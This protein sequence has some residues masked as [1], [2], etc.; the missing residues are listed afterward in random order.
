MLTKQQIETAYNI[1]IK[2]GFCG[3]CRWTLD[4]KQCHQRGCYQHAVKIIQEVMRN[5]YKE[6]D[7]EQKLQE[8]TNCKIKHDN[9][10]KIVV[11]EGR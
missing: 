10:N 4:S 3:D 8:H 6:Y 9:G 11:V 1:S 2:Y 7:W 5:A